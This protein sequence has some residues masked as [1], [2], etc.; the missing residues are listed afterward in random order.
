VFFGR[1]YFL[2]ISCAR[3]ALFETSRVVV[4]QLGCHAPAIVFFVTLDKT[5]GNFHRIDQQEKP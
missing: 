1:Y 3:F 4:T 2:D 5:G